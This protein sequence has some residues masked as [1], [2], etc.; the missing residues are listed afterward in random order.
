[1]YI[2]NISVIIPAYNEESRI[3]QTINQIGKYLKEH[4]KNYEIIVINDGSI[5]RTASLLAEACTRFAETKILQNDKNVGKGY[6]VKK[7]VLFSMS[8]AILICDADL[9]TPIEEIEKLI[10]WFNNGFDIVI[11]SRRLKDSEIVIRQPWYREK[12]GCIFNIL[13]RGLTISG[14]KDTQC[15]F[16]LFNAEIARKIFNK[17]R[18]NGFSYDVEILF[19]SMLNGFKIKEVPV[20]W[21]HSPD[22]KIK[23]LKDSFKM[24]IDLFKIRFYYLCGTYK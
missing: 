4:F 17:S 1:M 20:R 19:I 8:S 11:G 7:G 10:P 13:V 15:G 9:S 3:L 24:L 2:N 22:S 21:S 16:K 23:L 18:I 14:I 5:D 6:S 12:M